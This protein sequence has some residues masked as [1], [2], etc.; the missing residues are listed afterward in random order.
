MSCA[1]FKSLYLIA[2]SV[3][4]GSEVAH[5]RRDEVDAVQNGKP[6]AEMHKHQI[7]NHLIL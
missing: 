1:H 3:Q 6:A 4:G 5:I 7:R 2:D